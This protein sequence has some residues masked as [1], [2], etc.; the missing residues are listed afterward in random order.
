MKSES[1]APVIYSPIVVGRTRG[2]VKC[3]SSFSLTEGHWLV[4]PF[5]CVCDLFW[6]PF[7]VFLSISSPLKTSAV[8][9]LWINLSK[10]FEVLSQKV[11]DGK[12]LTTLFSCTCSFWKQHM[13]AC[14]FLH[15]QYLLCIRC[16]SCLYVLLFSTCTCKNIRPKIDSFVAARKWADAHSRKSI[17]RAISPA[18]FR[19]NGS[20]LSCCN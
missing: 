8:A 15:Y 5:E 2:N 10:S 14:L 13:A 4:F 9:S 19:W 16:H 6:V 12:Q 7:A 18:A 3:K 11:R 17:I 20:L 1:V